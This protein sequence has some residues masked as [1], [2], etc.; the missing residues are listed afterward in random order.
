MNIPRIFITRIHIALIAF[1]V[2]VTA[3]TGYSDQVKLEVAMEHPFL[4]AGQKHQTHLKVGLTGFERRSADDRA[5]VN[6]AIVLDKSGSMSGRKIAEACAAAIIAVQQLQP[7]DIVSIV[8]YDDNVEV[9]VPATKL[10]DRKPVIAAIRGITAG[11]HTALFA[12]VSKGAAE[13]RKF[14]DRERVNRIILLSDGLANVGPSSP[15]DLGQLGKTLGK[16]GIS[17]STI[18]LGDGYNEDLMVKLAQ[19]SDGN[20]A[21]AASAE[22]LPD[23]FRSEF[24]DVLSVVAQEVLVQIK[25][26]PGIRPVKV[27]G[28]DADIDGQNVTVHLNQLLS[29]NEKY[30]LLEVE[31]PVTKANSTLP[32]ATVQLSYANMVTKTTDELTSTV[33]VRFTDDKAVVAQ[34]AEKNV[35]VAVVTQKVLDANDVAIKLR[36]EGRIEEAEKV[37]SANGVY[38]DEINVVLHS[39]ELDTLKHYNEHDVKNIKSDKAWVTQRKFMKDTARNRRSQQSYDPRSAQQ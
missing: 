28:R 37:L 15:N 18:G 30:V 34:E 14:I 25:C 7:Q 12:G 10:T 24:G 11:G 16:E 31:V 4:L 17:V 39:H 23:I 33:A 1:L 19:Y 35:Q 13:L 9:L 5:P 26:Q 20:H 6:V 2:G 3:L 22:V 36:D 21:F 32:V 29:N 27:L 38:I 8:T